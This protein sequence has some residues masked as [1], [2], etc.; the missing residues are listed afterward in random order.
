MPLFKLS[1]A[2]LTDPNR[3]ASSHRARDESAARAIAAGAFNVS[4]GF[5]PGRGVKVPPWRRDEL[6]PVE[7]IENPHWEADGPDEALY[8][9]FG[10]DLEG[11]PRNP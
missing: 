10:A 3:E 6:V 2:G 11:S 7:R 1:P 4:T 9:S 8:P 5:Q